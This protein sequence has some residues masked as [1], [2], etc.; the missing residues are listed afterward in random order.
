MNI[1]L[2]IATCY[3]DSFLTAF[4]HLCQ[5]KSVPKSDIWLL[6]QTYQRI[7]KAVRRFM[8]R[9]AAIV[10]Q[11]GQPDPEKPGTVFVPADKKDAF[12]AEI[13]ALIER[14]PFVNTCLE[15]P[16]V[17]KWVPN[18]SQLTAEDLVFLMQAGIVYDPDPQKPDENDS[19]ESTETTAAPSEEVRD[20]SNVAVDRVPAG[21]P[22]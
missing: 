1:Q 5:T 18:D 19:Q 14:D 9:R 11:Y 13:T 17:F 10:N 6:A 7:E 16:I 15:K 8:K 2:P 20:G 12:L 22:N 3:E 4:K 21:N